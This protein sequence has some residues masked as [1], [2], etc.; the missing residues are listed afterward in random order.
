MS[1]AILKYNG[2]TYIYIQ[3]HRLRSI[4]KKYLTIYKQKVMLYKVSKLDQND[5]KSEHPFDILV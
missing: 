2:E 3:V 4:D 5:S 1:P